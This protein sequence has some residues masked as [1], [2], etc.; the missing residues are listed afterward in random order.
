MWLLDEGLPISLYKLLQELDVKVETVE[1]RSWKGLRNGNLVSAA[2]EAGFICIL[3]KDRLFAQ[4]AKKSLSIYSHMSVVLI[5][6]PQQ[7]REQYLKNFKDHWSESKIAPI[8]GQLIEWPSGVA[9][10]I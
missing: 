9:D 8:A 10:S 1:F 7:P 2:A 4:D 6:L 5:D 3:T